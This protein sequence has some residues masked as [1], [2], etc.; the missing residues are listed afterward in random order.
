M[1]Q[2]HPARN[3]VLPDFEV[4][5]LNSLTGYELYIRV[6]ELYYAGWTLRA[7][8]DSLTPK[9]PRSTIRYWV[10]KDVPI[11]SAAPLPTPTAPIPIQVRSS[12]PKPKRGLTNGEVRRIQHLAPIARKFRSAMPTSHPAAQANTELSEF[13]VDLYKAHVPISEL[14]AAAGVSYRAMARRIERAS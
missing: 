12:G 14:A 10:T 7:I 1:T 4:K 13:V 2:R 3:Q 6:R 11:A 8:G 5:L 9:R